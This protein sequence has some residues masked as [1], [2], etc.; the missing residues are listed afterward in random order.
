M[1]TDPLH[2]LVAGLDLQT[3]LWWLAMILS[4]FLATFLAAFGFRDSGAFFVWLAVLVR[5]AIA[6][7]ISQQ[8]FGGVFGRL[9]VGEGFEGER[10]RVVEAAVDDRDERAP[11]RGRPR[12]VGVAETLGL[13]LCGRDR[14]V[15]SGAVAQLDQIFDRA[16]LRGE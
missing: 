4:G 8:P 14:G 5:L 11:A 16:E 12:P 3:D 6:V 1:K 9:L 15:H 2:E 10:L 13:Q 7:G